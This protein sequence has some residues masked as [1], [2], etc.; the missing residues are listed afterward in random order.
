MLKLRDLAVLATELWEEFD[1]LGG[2]KQPPSRGDVAQSIVED[3]GEE[4]LY[5]VADFLY[6]GPYINIGMLR[7]MLA[8]EVGAYPHT[9]AETL[10]E[11]NFSDN[12]ALESEGNYTTG[13]TVPQA[14]A[15]LKDLPSHSIISI[16]GMMD[17]VE[18][19]AFWRA[20]LGERVFP[21]GVY[22]FLCSLAWNIRGVRVESVR[23]A[24]CYMPY[25]QVISRIFND[26]ESLPTGGP[27]PRYPMLT[28]AFRM[29]GSA[30]IPKGDYYL[31]I[32]RGRRYIL[33][34][35]G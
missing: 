25:K 8:E 19:I 33:S 29:K 2:K 28:T 17:E 1:A 32:M 34:V 5:Q 27:D 16:M 22:T 4:V 26:K 12:L 35:W 11:E 20:A 24:S 9:I 7:A 6:G 30:A 21:Y 15:Y 31:D 23:W 13:L 10:N 3:G 18:A 14:V